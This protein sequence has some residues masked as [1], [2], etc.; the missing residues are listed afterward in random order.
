MFA[1]RRLTHF[2]AAL[3]SNRFYPINPF[4][5]Q[6]NEHHFVFNARNE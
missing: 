2:L 3:N 1:I 5:D 4:T 6:F